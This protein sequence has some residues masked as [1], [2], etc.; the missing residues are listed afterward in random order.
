MPL[1]TQEEAE[2]AVRPF[3]EQC[4]A[5][6]RS[7]FDDWLQGP[8]T[9][10]MQRKSLRANIISNQMLANARRVFDKVPGV[11]VDD[12]PGY[13]GLLV[14]DNIFI[15]MKK[16]DEN[17]ISRN[18]PTKSA[19]SYVDQSKDMFGGLVRLELVY[20]LGAYGTK[21]ERIALL[22]RHKSKIVWHIDLLD[23]GAAIQEVLPFAQ[24]PTP[25]GSAAQRVLKPKRKSKKEENDVS[26]G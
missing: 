5:V 17:L 11:R 19:L 10:Q 24:P 18:Y 9:H 3:A 8:Y 23:S 15:R 22:Q 1:I 14:G 6:I 4:V 26:T 12:V 2:Q 16:A 21:I 13:T 25:A 7:A 20:Q